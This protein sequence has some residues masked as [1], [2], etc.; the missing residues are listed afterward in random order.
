M[1]EFQGNSTPYFH[2][3]LAQLPCLALPVLPAETLS[4][5]TASLS[6]QRSDD[7][8]EPCSSNS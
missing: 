4:T 1:N 5:R 7:A 2:A 8:P 6:A 3:E